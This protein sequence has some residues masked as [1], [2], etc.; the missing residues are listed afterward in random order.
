MLTLEDIHGPRIFNESKKLKTKV[1]PL[2]YPITIRVVEGWIEV[3]Q[4]DL[5]ILVAKKQLSQITKSQEIG[6]LVLEVLN[7]ALKR[8]AYK[9][10]AGEDLPVPSLPID[11]N[12]FISIA[13]GAEKLGISV[14]TLRRYCDSKEL[15]SFRKTKKGGRFVKW[16]DIV[17]FGQSLYQERKPDPTKAEKIEMKKIWRGMKERCYNPANA[18]FKNYGER[19][20]R[21]CDRWL[22]SFDDFYSDMGS[23][24]KGYSI[25]RINNDGNYE[26]DNCR[27]ADAKTQANN[28]RR[29]IRKV[30]FEEKVQQSFI[31]QER[32][33]RRTESLIKSLKNID[34]P[35]RSKPTEELDLGGNGSSL[36]DLI[37]TFKPGIKKGVPLFEE[38]PLVHD[39]HQN[40]ESNLSLADMF[41]TPDAFFDQASNQN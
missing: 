23:R 12:E 33:R 28:T 20:I 2:L 19:G 39:I 27:W 34:I 36:E 30:T 11:P 5:G 8:A 17:A 9:E 24:P 21:I 14:S 6:D 40:S 10:K 37:K 35:S 15:N 4:R 26:P 32:R 31:F 18:S 3:T 13:A 41:L 16:M 38:N 22:H 7:E 25:D 1:N 29:T